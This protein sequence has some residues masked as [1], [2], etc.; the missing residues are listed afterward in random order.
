M[1][2]HTPVLWDVWPLDGERFCGLNHPPC[3]QL[4]Y[5]AP[6]NLTQLSKDLKASLHLLL[7]AI[8]YR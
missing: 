7:P 2:S 6:G 5:G 4:S 3:G 8:P 1:H